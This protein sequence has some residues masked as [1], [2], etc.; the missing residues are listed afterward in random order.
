MTLNKKLAALLV[1]AVVMVVG[2]ASVT[3]AYFT[4]SESAT[5]TFTVGKVNIELYEYDVN[6]DG[7]KTGNY[8]QDGNQYQLIPGTTYDK[9]AFVRVT[10]DSEP[11]WLFVTVDNP[12]SDI[13]GTPSIVSQMTQNTTEHFWQPIGTYTIGNKQQTVY[14]WEKIVGPGMDV[15]V[16]KTLTINGEVADN[17]AIAEAAQKDIEIKAYAI[18]AAGFD[19]AKAAWDKAYNQF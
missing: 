18:Q 5:N 14:A 13:E 9:Q 8:S 17:E 6:A 4:D 11:C 12:L 16:F 19:S 15:T 3:L 10:V 1:C 2:A 7:E